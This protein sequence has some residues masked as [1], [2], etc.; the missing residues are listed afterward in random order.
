MK[1]LPITPE[2]P[3][4]RI[5]CILTG[6][7]LS[8]EVVAA[9]NLVRF[10]RMSEAL[11]RRGHHVDLVVKTTVNG[12]WPCAPGLSAVSIDT[13]RWDDYDVIKTFFHAGFDALQKAGG[14]DHPF[15]VSNLGSVVA[16]EDVEGVYFYDDVRSQLWDVQQTVASRSRVISLLNDPNHNLFVRMH[17]DDG[18]LIRVPTGVD[19]EIP[20]PGENPYR[21]LGITRPVA[22]YAGN[23]YSRDKQALVNLLWQDRLNRLGRELWERG[24][25][26]V[27]MGPGAIDHIDSAVVKHVG[28]IDYRDVWTWQHHAAVG[29]TLAQ[30]LVQDNESSKIY[31]YLRTGLPVVCEAPVPNAHLVSD[32]GHG[33]VVAY[34]E[35]D[36]S[37]VAEAAVQLVRHRPDARGVVPYMIEH[38]SWDARA[39]VYEPYLAAAGD[40]TGSPRQDMYA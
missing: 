15:I 38:H 34:H 39:A 19:A 20:E 10:V 11:V 17:G 18:R 3:P 30:G 31:Y 9:M 35:R 16:N 21:A 6:R 36:L 13:V 37:A 22:L 1:R 33:A 24:I 2:E 5:A 25:Q 28:L 14:G 27:V 23:I 29:V 7:D 26:L 32:T 8:T 40:S 12:R 4:R